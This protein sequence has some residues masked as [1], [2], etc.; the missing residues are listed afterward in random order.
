MPHRTESE[1]RKLLGR[2]RE[3]MAGASAGQARLDRIVKLIASS[4]ETEVCSIYLFRDR[5]TLEL[6]A[7]EGLKPEA[8]HVT[9][10][11]LGEGLVGRVAQ[12]AQ[13]INT[14]NAPQERGF[15]YMPE[16]GEEIYSSFLGV[17]VQRLGEKLG[18][19]VV[20]S[21]VARGF[22][23]DEVYA[24]EVVA[25]VLAEM[26]ELGAFV[27]DG[28]ALKARHTQPVMIRGTSGQE[29]T[30][31]G[32]V[33]LHEPRVVITNP[34]AD[35]P[36]AEAERLHRAVET[37][38]LT[39]DAML[40]RTEDEGEQR[41]VFETYRMFANSRS[42]MRR[43]EEDIARGLS[44]EAAVEKEQSTARAR[45]EQVA[46]AY[47]RD[48]L[49]DLDD[50]SNRLLRI[51]TG[52]GADTGAELPP[53]PI[54]VARNIG[55][56]ELLEYGRKLKG[57]V[58]EQGSVGSHAAIV[59][60]AWAIPLVIHAD[61]I[62]SRGAERRPH[63]GRRRS[64]HRASAPRRHGGEGDPGQDGHAGR[65]AE[66]LRLAP[67]PAGGGEVRVGRGAAHER[68]ADGGPAV[69]GRL[70]RGGGGAV[71][72]G[73]AVPCPQQGAEA[74]GAGRALRPRDG[75]GQGQAGRVPHA[76]HR[77]GQGAAL[78]EAGGR[79]EPG[80]GL[81]GDPGGARQA[82]G[83]ADAVAGADPGGGGAAADGDVPVRGADGRI[84]RGAGASARRDRA[85][86]AAGA[87][88]A[89]EG[90]DRGDAGDAEPRLRA[91]GVLRDDGLPVD[92]G[93]RSQA[94]LL[95]RRPRERAG[96][97]ALRHAERELPAL[98]RADRGPL[99]RD[100]DA[101]ELLRRGCRA[102][103]GGACALRRWG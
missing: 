73:A 24:L 71:P 96:A 32:H 34:I 62:T 54:L 83:H 30:A 61:R 16:T 59:A 93:Q 15:R 47:I 95:R 6:C 51:L 28:A 58:L 12:R 1:S 103:G 90:R 82:R 64:G 69:A 88:P 3:V 67:R 41:E 76:R 85:G 29:G 20:Q 68:G 4:M 35:D 42:W 74:G 70:G 84:H 79:A 60:R 66:A 50:L 101:R 44:A 5:E 18:V 9:R 48:R 21:K 27:G 19:L 87:C 2:L 102:A 53:D 11:R 63:H 46:D 38:R 81:A 22:S 100:G 33:W 36:V 99:P 86:A 43:M 26:A 97:A 94:V 25:M 8:V 23:E 52:Q 55:P 45:M 39:V 75:R 49:H 65:G 17:P 31:E 72:D 80:A 78:H 57:I 7:T 92:R 13:P 14:A 77:V 89:R 56:G 40:S 98:H 10:M 37:L 91:A